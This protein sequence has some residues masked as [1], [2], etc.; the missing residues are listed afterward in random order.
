[1]TTSLFFRSAVLSLALVTSSGARDSTRPYIVIPGTRSPDGRHELA[2]TVKNDKA[3]EWDWDTLNRE[4]TAIE[5]LPDFDFEDV[6]GCMIDPRSG[7]VLAKLRCNFWVA[8]DGRKPNHHMLET[9]W[10][11]DGRWLVVLHQLR[12]DNGSMEV[13]H[14]KDGEVAGTLD[15]CEPLENSVRD[16]LKMRHGRRYD[17]DKE[18]IVIGFHGL[19]PWGDATFRFMACSGAPKRITE[20]VLEDDACVVFQV[21][22][23]EQGLGLKVLS[24]KAQ[25]A[26]DEILSTKELV[27]ADKELNRIYQAVRQ[28]LGEA[29][30]AELGKAQQAW[31]GQRDAI[32][33]EPERLA[34]IRKRTAELMARIAPPPGR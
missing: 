33:D 14:M 4:N 30:R 19:R 32:E 5:D 23:G 18:A 3:D 10:S 6:Q 26:A 16:Y 25:E 22:Q 28:S 34:F 24:I 12:F 8:P 20:G 17:R 11:K 13:V 7:R 27:D 9:A 29:Q 2:W 31:L 1:M 15:A 21:A